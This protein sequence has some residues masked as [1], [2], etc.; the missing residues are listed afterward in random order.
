MITMKEFEKLSSHLLRSMDY[1]E[2]GTFHK[3]NEKT[4][5][6]TYDEKEVERIKKILVKLEKEI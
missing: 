2:Q 3:Y 1:G 4:G 6:Y 5:E